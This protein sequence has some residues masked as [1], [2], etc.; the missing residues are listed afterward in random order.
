MSES[1]RVR[2]YMATDLVILDPNTEILRA[3]HTLLDNDISGAPVID[4]NGK[5]VGMLTERDCMRVVL[6]AGYHSQHGGPVSDYMSKDVKTVAAE[7]SIFDTAK[8]FFGERFHRYP[9]M[10]KDYVVGQISRRDVMRALGEL[11]S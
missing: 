8:L 5:L 11:W 3:V 4:G 2:D 7:D 1:V 6:H 10:Q 9:V